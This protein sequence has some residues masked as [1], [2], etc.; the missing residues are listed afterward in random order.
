[1]ARHF[2]ELGEDALSLRK[3]GLGLVPF[4][5]GVE[6]VQILGTVACRHRQEIR[7]PAKHGVDELEQVLA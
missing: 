5:F 1:M 3:D 6:A 7:P 4:Q 2:G